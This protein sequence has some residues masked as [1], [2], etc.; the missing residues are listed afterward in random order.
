ME[1]ETTQTNTTAKLPVLKNSFKPVAQT[2]TNDASNSTTLIPGPVTTKEK[3]QKKNDVKARKTRFG[4]NEAIKKTQKTLLK[5]QKI[6]IW[7]NKPD[8][9]TMSIDDLYNNFKIAEQEVKRTAS[10]K[11]SS[12][13]WLLCHLLVLTVLMK[14]ILF[15]ELVL[16]ALNLVLLA[17]KSQ[18]VYEDLEQIHEDDL[19]KMDLKWQLALLSMRAKRGPRNQDSRNGYQDSSKRTV[20]MGETP[21]KAVVAIDGVGFD[22]SYMSKNEVPINMFLMAFSDSELDLSNSSLEEFKQHEFESYG[23]KSYEKKSKNTSKDISNELKESPDAPLVKDRVSENKDCLVDYPVVGH[24]QKVQEDQGYVDSG[25]SRHMTGNMS[26]LS[27]FKEFYR[28]YV[29]FGG[30]VNGGRITGKGTLKTSKLDFKDVYFVKELN[31]NLISVSQMCDKKNS[32]LFTYTGCFVLSPNFKLTDESQVLLEVPRRNNMYSIDIKNIVPKESLTC[33]VAKAILDESK[34]WHRRLGH[35]NFKNINKLVKDKLVRGLPLKRFE[36][37]QTYVACLKEKQHKVSC[38]SKNRALVVKPHN[39]TPYELFRGRTVA[40]SFMRPFSKAFRVYN[41]RTRR[42]EENLHIEFL[43]NKPIVA[44]AGPKCVFDID[45]LTQSMNYVP[46]IAGTNSNDFAGIKDS[47]GAGQ[48]NMKTGSTQDYIYMP[49]WKDGSPLFDSSP[50]IFDDAGSPSFGD[51]GKK[52]DEALDKESGALNELNYAFENLNTKYPD[53]PKMLSLETIATNNDSEEEANFTNVESLIH[54]SLPPT[55]KTHKNHPLKQVIGSLNTPV[56]TR[57]KLKPTN[58]QKFISV[59]YEGKTHKDLNTCLFAYFLSQIRVARALFDP[60]WVKAMQEEL[61]QFK[62]QK[63]WILVDLPKGKKAIGTKSVFENKKDEKGMVIKNKAR[64]VAQGYT[65]EEGIDYDKVFA[66]VAR[67]KA[68][69]LFLAYASFMGFMVYQMD[70]KSVFL[71]GKIE[72]EVYTCQPSGFE[73]PEHP[74]KVYKVVKALY[75]LHQALRAWYETLANYQLGNGFHKGKIDQ[76]ELCTEFKRL[77]KDKFQMSSMRELTLFLGLQV[78]QKEDRIFISHDK[79]VVKGLRK[80]S[81]LNVKSANTPVDME[82]T[83]VKGSCGDDVDVHLY[84]SM[85][86]SLMYLT[87]S[88]P[89][90]MYAV[91]VCARFQ[92]TP[93]VSYVHVVKRIFRYLKGHSKLGLWYLKDSLFKLVSYTNN[94]YAGASLDRKSTTGGCQFLRSRLISW[95]CKK[96]TM[97]ATSTTE[98]EYV[99]AASC[100][101]QVVK[102]S[103]MVGF[104]K[105]IQYKLTIGINLLLLVSVTA[106][107]TKLM[108]LCKLTTAIDVNVV[109]E[110]GVKFLMFSRFV[111]VLL[112]SQVE[113]MLKHKEIY[114]TPSHTKKIFANMKRQGKDFSGKVTPLFETMMVQ[115]QEDMGED[116][117]IPTD[118]HHTPTVT[119]PSTSPQPQQK[120]LSKKYKTKITEVPQLSDSTHYVADEHVTTTPLS[121]EDRLKLTELMEICTQLQSRVLSLETTKV[122]QALK[123]GSLKIWMK[124]LKKKASKQTHKLKRLYK[125]G[126][127]LVDETKGR[128]D[129]DM[130]DTSIFDDEEVVAEKEVSTAAGVKVSTASITTQISMDEITSAKALIDIKTSKPK[131]NEKVVEDS[132]KAVKGSKKA[133]EG[134]S[135]RAANKLEQEDA[136]RQRID[137]ENESAELKR[138]LEITPEDDDDDVIIEAT[139]LS[140]KSPTIVD[141]KIYKEGRKSFFKIIKADDNIWKYQQGTTKVLNWKLFDSYGVYCVT[142]KNMVYYLLVKKMYPF[143]RNILNQMWNDVRLQVEYEVDMAYDLLRLIKRQISEGYELGQEFWGITT[144]A[145]KAILLGADNRPPMLEKDMYDSWKIKMKQYMLNGQHGRMI[146]ESVENGP[147]LWPTVK[148]NGVTRPKKYSKLSATEANQADCDVKA[149]NIILQRLPPEVY[150]LVSNHKVAKELW[151]RIQMLMQGTSLTKQERECKLYDE[152]DKF[153]YKKGESLRDFYLRFSLFLNDMNIY[154]MK[155]EQFK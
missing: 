52:H 29:T 3:A 56:Q 10:S 68:I 139:P 72:E 55:T 59:V 144:L 17:L 47:I 145:D 101:G 31:F 36:N 87:A 30:G 99:A 42:V 89:D 28:G 137:E 25:C 86:R 16:L 43:E 129:Q 92:V 138:C 114:V 102:Q 95:Q 136:K 112:D 8:L 18:L 90:I 124:K 123:I 141:Y 85:I 94:D 104:G 1:L 150:A 37:D 151:E 88:R 58:K 33:L 91:C 66:P 45:M 71:Y 109:E 13:T 63:V 27:D 122:D 46:V 6:V 149:T 96:Q 76:T 125:I 7:R 57:S 9:D 78:K 116:S 49:L 4:G 15:M 133:K 110:D 24:P 21:P 74:D 132:E 118:S 32:V 35:I 82:K 81:F 19:E 115:P 152:F 148:E 23:P 107:S 153:A 77:R 51:A 146:L 61:L 44:G 22:S 126:V 69:R 64:L 142:I 34:L 54:V 41:I 119:Q 105:M 98:A 67:I 50:K 2:T 73:D 79:Y 5:L 26:D 127:A 65:Q 130:F 100:C 120:Q 83:L 147:L 108:L 38:K 93:K 121:G 155:L 39:K 143:T 103:S 80:F 140:S 20:N 128:N 135:K 106:A 97:V 12:Q 154:N 11:S 131:A 14:F 60:A 70:V 40:L 53:D 113:G 84:R 48:S 111:Q 117:E 62:L 134:S 75:G